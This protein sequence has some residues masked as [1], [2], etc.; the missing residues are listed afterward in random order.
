MGLKD[1]SIGVVESQKDFFSVSRGPNFG[2]EQEVHPQSFTG[3]SPTG[4]IEALEVQS[5]DRHSEAVRG[6]FVGEQ[7]KCGTCA[8]KGLE[9]F[10]GFLTD[11]SGKRRILSDHRRNV[12]RFRPGLREAVG[13]QASDEQASQPA[14]QSGPQARTQCDRLRGLQW[15]ECVRSHRRCR[16]LEAA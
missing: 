13:R 16:S 5:V 4:F 12:K 2:M 9:A 10:F 7:I 1:A 6:H 8:Q 3:S 15:K 14:E 11:A